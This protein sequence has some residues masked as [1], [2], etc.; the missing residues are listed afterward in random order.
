MIWV[1]AIIFHVGLVL[2]AYK[3]GTNNAGR[4]IAILAAGIIGFQLFVG[5]PS[6]FLDGGCSSYGTH[7]KDC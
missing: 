7:A 4:G 6:S 3:F 5:G 1:I 2:L